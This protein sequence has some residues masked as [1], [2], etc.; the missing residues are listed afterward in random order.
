MRFGGARLDL[1]A[2]PDIIGLSPAT[3]NLL[4]AAHGDIGCWRLVENRTSFERVAREHG[5]VDGV[6]WLPGFAPTWWKQSVAQLL[7]YKPAP[8]HIA[9]DPDPAGICIALEAAGVWEANNLAW[10]TWKMSLGDLMQLDT[11]LP[12]SSHDKVLLE[13]LLARDL[14]AELR[15]LAHGMQAHN[16]K[17]EQEGYL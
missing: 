9:C 4:D 13:Q 5:N 3:L 15:E 10:S 6:I 14:P 16:A 2:V 1:S 17:G 11:R 7:R 12:L 8:A